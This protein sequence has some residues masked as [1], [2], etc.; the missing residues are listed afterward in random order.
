MT[1]PKAKTLQQRFGFRDSDLKT[2]KHD[3]MMLWL[4]ENMVDFLDQNNLWTMQ[5]YDTK[6]RKLAI[7]Q[8]IERELA[9]AR[10]G[11]EQCE[12]KAANYEAK[13]IELNRELY[14]NWAKNE[15]ERAQEWQDNVDLLESAVSIRFADTPSLP[16]PKDLLRIKWESFIT[17]GRNKYP[18][19]FIDMVV[20]FPAGR[21]YDFDNF[22]GM[23]SLNNLPP[24]LLKWC[25][26]P[27]YINHLGGYCGDLGYADTRINIEIKTKI[28]SLGEL[29]R[30]IRMYQKHVCGRWIVVCPD[31][32]FK[33]PLASQGIALIKHTGD[34]TQKRLI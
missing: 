17:S 32:R 33:E 30:Q 6:Q 13:A 21:S 27:V 20:I 25:I 34:V 24:P 28:P 5:E 7:V 12:K 19:G 29:I 22:S 9:D 4:H 3:E 1:A 18:I 11:L 16:N 15:R 31:D 10:Q 23:I 26:T 14:S 8:D 2:P